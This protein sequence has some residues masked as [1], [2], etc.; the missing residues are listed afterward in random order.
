MKLI[1]EF[2]GGRLFRVGRIPVLDLH[3]SYHAMGRQYGYLLKDH[4]H[5]LY[6]TAVEDYFI[7]A[8]NIPYERLKRIGIDIFDLYPRRFK[9]MIYGMAETSDMSVGKHIILNGLEYYG[10]LFGCSGIAVWN[11]FTSGGPLLFG[12]NYDWYSHYREFA[13][14]LTVTVLHPESS[15]ASA[16]IMFAGVIYATTGLNECGLFL[17]LNN[18]MPVSG[19]SNYSN[20]VPIIIKLLTFLQDHST[21][22]QLDA[23]LNSTRAN[24]AYIINV[25]DRDGAYSY[26]CSTYDIMRLTGDPRGLLVATNHFVHHSWGTMRERDTNFK[27]ITR[28]EN[29]IRC[30]RQ[31]LGAFSLSKMK[32]LLDL[33]LPR[34]ATWPPG[35]R[36]QTVYQAIAVPDDLTIWLKIPAVQEWSE[37]PLGSIFPENDR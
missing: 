16:I 3:G 9:T 34:G 27:T 20:R 24:Y 28:R 23:A 17:E 19:D 4:L 2:E 33:P 21:M 14:Y 12:R 11:E 25:A 1:D 10:L 7:G 15:Y 5:G 32:E 37:I 18:G 13:S 22:K 26:E 8:Q 30:A 36:I 31:S 35:E 6:R 29:L